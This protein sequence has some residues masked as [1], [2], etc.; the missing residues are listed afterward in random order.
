MSN[1]MA[2]LNGSAGQY[3]IPAVVLAATFLA[4]WTARWIFKRL[5]TGRFR[6]LSELGPSLANLIYVVGLKI[7]MDGLPLNPKVERWLD[8]GFYVLTVL[9]LLGL[10]RRA[11]LT[12]VEWSASK[13]Q[14]SATLQ[15]GF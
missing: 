14:N 13:A 6:F 10:F 1:F 12:A 4:V 11:A 8:A 9:I 2:D 3:F 5:S 7:A 15:Q